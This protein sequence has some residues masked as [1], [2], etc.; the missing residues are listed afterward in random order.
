M[1]LWDESKTEIHVEGNR[2]R[3]KQVDKLVEPESM[4]HSKMA[5][6]L[7]NFPKWKLLPDIP[8]EMVPSPKATKISDRRGLP[9]NNGVV[10]I[11]KYLIDTKLMDSRGDSESETVLDSDVKRIYETADVVL[12]D[13]TD[14]SDISDFSD[15]SSED[16]TFVHSTLASETN[17]SLTTGD[18]DTQLNQ[19]KDFPQY[20][21][22]ERVGVPTVGM[23]CFTL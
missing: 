20:E 11:T 19:N 9:K 8:F 14:C 5:A 7:K 1:K 21:T 15:S 17:M 23:S 18:G 22:Q 3:K 6:K 16:D 10:T 12:S 4:L 2:Q 13:T